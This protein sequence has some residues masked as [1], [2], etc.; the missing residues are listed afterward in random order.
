L[1]YLLLNFIQINRLEWKPEEY[2]NIKQITLNANRIWLPDIVLENG[3]GQNEYLTQYKLFNPWVEYTGKVVWVPEVQIFTK[4]II[5]VKDFPFDKQCCEI[6]LYSWAHTAEQMTILQFGN[7]NV[8]NLTHLAHNTE[9]NIYNTC[10]KNETITIGE[11]T[12]WWITTYVIKIKRESIYYFY[13][14]LMP[15]AVLSLCS[16]LMFW[17]PP[18]SEEKITL[19]VT[20]LLAFFVN[21]LIVSNYTPEASSE[22]PVIGKDL[23]K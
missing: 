5:K 12:L 7:K 15:C 9:W 8:T 1:K 16:L 6:S 14:L 2:D 20:I 23:V 4:C 18:D 22:L 13:T 3:V 17:L 11:G 21:S 10:A 19:G